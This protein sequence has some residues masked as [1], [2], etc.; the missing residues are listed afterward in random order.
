MDVLRETEL[1]GS[2]PAL[3][4]LD[5][6]H[7]LSKYISIPFSNSTCFRSLIDKLLYLNHTRPDNSYFVCRLNQFLYQ[8]K[9]IHLQATWRIIHFIKKTLAQ[10]LLIKTEFNHTLTCFT[11]SNWGSCKD[12]RR[13]TN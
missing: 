3:T 12:T 1:L 5:P 13:F 9:D 6:N 10:V 8:V 2:K 7:N 11:D 4:I